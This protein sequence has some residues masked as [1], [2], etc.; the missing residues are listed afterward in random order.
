MKKTKF[1]SLLTAATMLF[2]CIPYSAGAQKLTGLT[3]EVSEDFYGYA[4]GGQNGTWT[5]TGTDGLSIAEDGKNA[6]C[7]K[8]SAAGA[9]ISHDFASVLGRD[10]ILEISYDVKTSA[11][12]APTGIKFEKSSGESAVFRFDGNTNYRNYSLDSNLRFWDANS[13]NAYA[14]DTWR[15][16]TYSIDAF[17]NSYDIYEN[18]EII[19][20]NRACMY[21]ADRY[22][23][24]FAGVNKISF[25][26]SD[27]TEGDVYFD[28]INVVRIK[29]SNYAPKN[30]STDFSELINKDGE[31]RQVANGF[32]KLYRANCI[33]TKIVDK[34]HGP[35]YALCGTGDTIIAASE[36]E[37]PVT[38]GTVTVEFEQYANGVTNAI[39]LTHPGIDC[40]AA[41]VGDH[42]MSSNPGNT[43]KWV[44][45][46]FI[47]DFS[48]GTYKHYYDGVLQKD[49][50]LSGNVKNNGLKSFS[51]RNWSGT[52]G[53]DVYID[54]LEVRVENAPSQTLGF[55]DNF[56]AYE[57]VNDT[58]ANW[59]YPVPGTPASC[60]IEGT[61]NKVFN[62][63]VSPT[64]GTSVVTKSLG[65]DISK[66]KV[67]IDFKVK[68]TSGTKDGNPQNIDWVLFL[69]DKSWGGNNF[70]AALS[71]AKDLSIKSGR[72]GNKVG[73][74]ELDKWYDCSLSV[75]M[76]STP[77]RITTVIKDTDGAEIVNKTS[78]FVK[79]DGSSIDVINF[80]RLQTYP[81]STGYVSLDDVKA[82][83]VSDLPAFYDVSFTDTD[84]NT[85]KNFIDVTPAI[86]AVNVDFGTLM[87][88]E[89]ITN[90]TFYLENVTDGVKEQYSGELNGTVYTMNFETLLMPEKN[91]RLTLTTDA[92][93]IQGLGAGEIQYIDFN[94]G[95]GEVSAV[96]T[97]VK[98]NNAE[99][100]DISQLSQNNVVRV[101]FK[102]LNTTASDLSAYLIYSY[103]K[104]DKL[105]YT[106]YK[107][108]SFQKDIKDVKISIPQQLA[109]DTN[110]ADNVKIFLWDGVDSIVPLAVNYD[111]NSAK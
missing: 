15:S 43:G 69:S 76:S 90:E 29:R 83:Y 31:K 108:I 26:K 4:V 104:G 58:K 87:K 35:S 93:N 20:H 68:M 95:K 6:E 103:Y 51:F 38:E 28:N 102:L 66:G 30:H 3:Y 96:I 54:N 18:G 24:E 65:G 23:F 88:P 37:S 16:V 14:P 61:D 73:E 99:L 105:T 53:K 10:E 1:L 11:A 98:F 44:K 74:Y 12:T 34:A 49:A 57:T 52:V 21:N 19:G 72:L 27:G 92:K 22:I 32:T 111:F 64:D 59:N 81:I 91:Y 9:G 50:A 5:E 100:S 48:S 46:K 41:G 7:I 17:T 62:I 79:D 2:A 36:F 89:T 77:A 75:N 63:G 60:S 45:C 101:D 39:Y 97:G 47:V 8:I 71:F 86:T 25:I 78:D 56:D 55:S 70:A 13:N 84:N 80:L 85:T 106:Y 107:N 67:N 42:V 94:T 109:K 40:A 33:G 110:S 82:E